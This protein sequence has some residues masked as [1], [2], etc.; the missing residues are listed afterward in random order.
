LIRW[1]QISNSSDEIFVTARELSIVPNVKHSQCKQAALTRITRQL[2]VLTAREKNDAGANL[3]PITTKGAE[4]CCFINFRMRFVDCLGDL[5]RDQSRGCHG[6]FQI[7]SLRTHRRFRSGP[8]GHLSSH[9][10]EKLAHSTD[11]AAVTAIRNHDDPYACIERT[12]A[13]EKLV[14][15]QHAVKQ[16]P[17]L[18]K[19]IVLVVI[20]IR[21]LAAVTGNT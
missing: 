17:S 5:W 13:L 8:D 4:L 6:S 21:Y 16:D 14:V 12:P 11:S 18:I 19:T 3:R 1:Q 9:V 10:F 2:V 15:D 20:L 7:Q